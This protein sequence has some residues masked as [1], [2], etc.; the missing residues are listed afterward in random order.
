VGKDGCQDRLSFFAKGDLIIT[1]VR[2]ELNELHTSA[3]SSLMVYID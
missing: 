1:T 3:K 2:R